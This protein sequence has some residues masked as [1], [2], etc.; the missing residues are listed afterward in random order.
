[1]CLEPFAVAGFVFEAAAAGAWV[2]TAHF[3]VGLGG[4]RF[5]VAA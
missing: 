1:M 4:R 3:G 5:G 2:V